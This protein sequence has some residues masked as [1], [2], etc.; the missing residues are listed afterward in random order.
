MIEINNLTRQRIDKKE[1]LRISEVFL[2]KYKKNKKDISIAFVGDVKM[3]SLNRT[4]RNKDKTTDVLSFEGE[5]DDLGEVLIN[6]Q[7]IKRQAKKNNQSVRQ[8]LLFILVH[9]FLHLL[10]Y[11]D[12]TEARRQ[13]MINLANVFLEKNL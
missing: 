3:R 7:E 13:K 4:Y 8:E 12:D 6:I 10:G 11:N 9:G 5:G 2:K 1:I